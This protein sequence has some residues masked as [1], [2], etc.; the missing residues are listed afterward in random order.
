[1]KTVLA[2]GTLL[3]CALAFPARANTEIQ[4][5]VPSMI[6]KQHAATVEI[7]VLLN[8]TGN[9]PEDIQLQW[10]VTDG[11]AVQGVNYESGNPAFRNVT[12]PVGTSQS[13][14]PITILFARSASDTTFTVTLS[15]T[16]S[17][18]PQVNSPSAIPITIQGLPPRYFL[19]ARH[20]QNAHRRLANVRR[21]VFGPERSA[22]IRRLN[23]RIRLLQA[24]MEAMS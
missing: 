14:V 15:G 4:F 18:N 8:N 21:F 12:A 1:M 16:G 7:P 13:A 19:L 17:P 23:V 3:T 5:A 20:L 6:V 10:S 11:S 2:L 24:R 22:I 9:Q